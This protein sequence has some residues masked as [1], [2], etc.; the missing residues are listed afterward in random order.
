MTYYLVA[1]QNTIQAKG[2]K[3]TAI[4][5]DK[6]QSDRT[7]ALEEFKSGRVPLMIAT[8][9]AVCRYVSYYYVLLHQLQNH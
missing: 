2:Y 4:H 6:S 5:G 7:A 1:L 9:V 3:V 8:D